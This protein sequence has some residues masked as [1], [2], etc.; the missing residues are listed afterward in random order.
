MLTFFPMKTYSS[1]PI[2]NKDRLAFIDQICRNAYE[3]RNPEGDLENRINPFWHDYQSGDVELV[4]PVMPRIRH[5]DLG[6]MPGLVMLRSPEGCLMPVTYSGENETEIIRRHQAAMTSTVTLPPINLKRAFL[7]EEDFSICEGNLPSSLNRVGDLLDR[8]RT[9]LDLAAA[10]LPEGRLCVALACDKRKLKVYFHKCAD[11]VDALLERL[12]A[13]IQKACE[14]VRPSF[15]REFSGVFA[16]PAWHASVLLDWANPSGTT[17]WEV[18]AVNSPEGERGIWLSNS[19]YRADE[20]CLEHHAGPSASIPTD[21]I[22]AQNRLAQRLLRSRSCFG[23][24]YADL[25]E[26]LQTVFR[27]VTHINNCRSDMNLGANKEAT[28]YLNDA[29]LIA[30]FNRWAF[31]RLEALRC[32]LHRKLEDRARDLYL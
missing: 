11:Y 12:I 6:V 5:K 15:Y 4:Y 8:L 29:G 25:L 30:S 23:S 31:K 20:E 16:K 21:A 27:V 1:V 28:I 2:R 19:L 14:S 32:T 24:D 18:L 10:A 17:F 3:S 22:A 26:E 9:A 7:V 13:D